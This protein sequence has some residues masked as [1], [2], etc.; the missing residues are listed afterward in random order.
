[1]VASYRGSSTIERYIDPQRALGRTD[2]AMPK[3]IDER[4]PRASTQEG[5]EDFYEFRVVNQKQFAR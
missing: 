1:M 3:Y 5:L 2:G 4:N